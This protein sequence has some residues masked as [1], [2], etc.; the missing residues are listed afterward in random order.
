MAAELIGRCKCPLCNSDKARLTLA[1][2]QLAVIT[3]NGCNFQGFARSDRSDELLRARLVADPAPQPEPKP[4][5]E[6]KPTP[7][8][9]KPQPEPEPK[10]APAAP[11][12]SPFGLMN[13]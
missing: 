2:S 12:R 7:T 9:P 13:W 11:A 6:P 10:P 4:A 3:C 8:A 5:P 1:K